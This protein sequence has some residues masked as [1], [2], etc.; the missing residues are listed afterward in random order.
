[1]RLARSTKP[2]ARAKAVACARIADDKKAEAITIL[3]LRGLTYI[4]DYFVI[5]TGQNPRQLGAIAEEIRSAMKKAGDRLI[6]EDGA[7]FGHWIV[8]DY[9]DFVIHLFDL[10]Y[11]KIYDLE[12]LWGDAKRVKWQKRVRTAKVE[13]APKSDGRRRGA[14]AA[15][16]G[17]AE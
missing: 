12:L 2:T 6:A 3:D 5:A 17:D 4:T 16:N 8:M 7:E 11:R 9:G 14:K 15:K 13:D 10:E 1:M